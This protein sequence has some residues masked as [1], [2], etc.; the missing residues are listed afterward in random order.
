MSSNYSTIDEILEFISKIHHK[1]IC[2]HPFPDGNG[3]I[4]RVIIDQLCLAYG[5]PMVMGTY[6]RTNR[7]QRKAYHSA[8]RLASVEN[9]YSYLKSWL[10]QRI[11]TQFMA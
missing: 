3:R 11:E 4:G 8:I 10:N 5:M 2:I 6:P 9:D 7:K 1:F